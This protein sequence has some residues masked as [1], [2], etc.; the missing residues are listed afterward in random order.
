MKKKAM[1]L[2]RQ[3][4]DAVE[5]AKLSLKFDEIVVAKRG[6][7]CVDA[8]SALPGKCQTSALSLLNT[9]CTYSAMELGCRIC[10]P[11]EGVDKPAYD[12]GIENICLPLKVNLEVAKGSTQRQIGSV[13]QAPAVIHCLRGIQVSCFG[14]L[15]Q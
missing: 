11:K 14:A 12:L 10:D 4:A 8:C 13:M 6:E 3:M 7:S 15:M 1:A 2:R 9:K 5:N